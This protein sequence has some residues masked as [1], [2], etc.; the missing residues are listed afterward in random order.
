MKKFP[1][2]DNVRFF[3][4]FTQRHIKDFWRP[5]WWLLNLVVVPPG[6]LQLDLDSSRFCREGKQEGARKGYNPKRK[7]C[8]SHHP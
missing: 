4:R 6:G 2:D 8:A 1:S 3:R 5:L 7:G